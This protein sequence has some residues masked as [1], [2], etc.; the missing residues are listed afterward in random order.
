M[1]AERRS[2]A[3]DRARRCRRAREQ[4][5]SGSPAAGAHNSSFSAALAGGSAVTYVPPSS[6]QPVP[7]MGGSKSKEDAHDSNRARSRTGQN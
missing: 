3:F 1:H 6:E 5:A 4:R 7:H 2:L